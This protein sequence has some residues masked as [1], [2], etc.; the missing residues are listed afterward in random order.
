MD[1][2]VPYNVFNKR[3]SE[4]TIEHVASIINYL[5]QNRSQRRRLEKALGRSKKLSEKAQDKISKKAYSEYQS[6]IDKD[7]IHFFAILSL[8]M[9]EDYKWKEDDTHDQI[10]SLLERV[11]KK[12]DKYSNAGYTTDDLVKLV[13]DNYGLV[14]VPDRH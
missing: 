12:L 8:V 5:G 7:F 13:E 4:E 9:G 1:S 3:N 6:L 11:G 2:N 14:L 10:S